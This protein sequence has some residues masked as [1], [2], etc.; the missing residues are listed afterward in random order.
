M[1]RPHERDY[2]APTPSRT[3]RFFRTFIPWQLWRFAWINLKMIRMISLGPHGLA[4][5]RPIVLGHLE[6]RRE[7]PPGE[8]H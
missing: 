1:A 4:P 5:A 6:L 8:A 2:C 3:T 7:R